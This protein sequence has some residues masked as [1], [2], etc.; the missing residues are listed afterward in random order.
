MRLFL[1]AL[2]LLVVTTPAGAQWL[3]RK[4][5]GLPRT[6]DGKPNLTAPAPRGPDGK[7]DLTG[8]WNGP[9]PE[10][11]LDPANEKPATNAIV[12]QRTQE[13]WK[14]R[15]SYQCLPSGPE[16]DRSA[17]WKRILQTPAA[18]AILNDDLTYRLIHMDGRQLEKDPAP[19]WQGY[20]VGRWEGDTL[21][22]DSNGYNDKTWLSRYGQPHTS[23]LHVTERFLRKDV[24]HL[25]VEVTYTD[26][27]AY[28]KPWSFTSD[29][30]LAADT[31]ML[32]AVCEQTSDRWGGSISDAANAGVTVAPDVL[33]RYVGVYSGMYLTNKRTIEVS[34]SGGQLM[35]KIIGAAAV[36][37]GE[38]RPL[39]AR[40]Q[41]VFEGLGIGYRFIVNDKGEATGLV[42][43]HISG[44]STFQ[45]QR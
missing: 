28:V 2:T 12:R 5:P 38:M 45:K 23:A 30:A 36:D 25:H 44:D 6:A 37:G 27:E 11:P 7:P 16:A 32:E 10:L 21:V 1:A 15:P 17:G 22:V 31:D 41:T 34:V 14:A 20:S 4:T 24:G 18:I 39:L 33:A 42:E 26:P 40:S 29:M 19:S 3:D 35:A 8:V 13:Y 43:I 9:V